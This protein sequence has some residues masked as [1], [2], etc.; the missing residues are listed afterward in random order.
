MDHNLKIKNNVVVG[1]EDEFVEEIIIPEGI[2]KIANYAFDKFYGLKKIVLP[3]SLTSI[4][5]F[6]FQK[7][8]S[9]QSIEFS[10]NIEFLGEGAFKECTSL[11]EV[12]MSNSKLTQIPYAQG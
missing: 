9:L 10:H 3:T 7:C 6:A 8:S 11:T 2:V 4:G 1:F 5:D 12:D